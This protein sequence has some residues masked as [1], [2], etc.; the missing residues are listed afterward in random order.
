MSFGDAGLGLRQ[1]YTVT[2]IKGRVATPITGSGPFFAVPANVG[3]RT[4]DYNALVDAGTHRILAVRQTRTA[5]A[6]EEAM[7]NAPGR[8]WRADFSTRC[9]C[10]SWWCVCCED[11]VEEIVVEAE[12]VEFVEPD[13]ET[14]ED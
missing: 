13:P 5:E 7:R 8:V 6:L 9:D 10:G 1:R 11:E 3:P 4:L 12:D 14:G 2:M